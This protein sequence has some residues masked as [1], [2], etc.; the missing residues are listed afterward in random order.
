MRVLITNVSAV[1]PYI[2]YQIHVR[3]GHGHC[4]VHQRR[5]RRRKYEFRGVRIGRSFWQRRAI[6]TLPDVT[7]KQKES[8]LP[9]STR[10]L[11]G[12]AAA[13]AAVKTWVSTGTRLYVCICVCVC[14]SDSVYARISFTPQPYRRRVHR[15]LVFECIV[16]VRLLLSTRVHHTAHRTHRSL[17]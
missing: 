17:V 5:R 7:I 14:V 6:T 9:F 12:A 4:W 15:K 3:F 13:P 16:V 11:F 10:R 2:L 1:Y 8:M